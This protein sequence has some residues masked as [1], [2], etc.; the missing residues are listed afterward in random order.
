MQEFRS[1]FQK[2]AA[3]ASLVA[4]LL[5]PASVR[6]DF[7]YHFDDVF[8]GTGPA[9]GT[10]W[11][12]AL[13]TDISPGTVTLKVSNVGLVDA[14]FVSE[15]YLNINPAYNPTSLIFTPVSSSGGFATPTINLGTDGFKADG[16][17]KY[18]IRFNFLT[19]SGNTFSAGESFTYQI[20][21]VPTLVASDFIFLSTPAGGHGP[22]DAAIHVQGICNDASGWADPH[23]GAVIVLVPE[24]A[25]GVLLVLAAGLF[26][27]GRR[28]LKRARG[29]Q[30]LAR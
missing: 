18:D 23:N 15:L 22:F 17:G 21:G 7:F 29:I 10:P 24:P 11:V 9:G 20:T 12:D 19:S 30:R 27:Y 1:R 5:A 25:P 14:E 2:M 3:S 28:L 16:D 26:F 13:F 4:A 8:S 6:A